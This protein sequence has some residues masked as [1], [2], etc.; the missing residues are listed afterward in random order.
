MAQGL[1]AASSHPAA[2][3]GQS[4][5]LHRLRALKHHS[6]QSEH[7]TAALWQRRRALH[8]SA[9]AAGASGAPA[10]LRERP[11]QAQVQEEQG[12]RQLARQEGR[13]RQ[14]L[15]V[16]APLER[17]HLRQG[18]TLRKTQHGVRRLAAE[19]EAERGERDA[20]PARWPVSG[21]LPKG[22]GEPQQ[23]RPSRRVCCLSHMQGFA[24]VCPLPGP[25]A[26]GSPSR[27]Q[28]R[29]SGK[30]GGRW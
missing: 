9:N 17:E 27:T 8:G 26:R 12:Q 2:A 24:N 20:R 23:A 11:Q 16:H 1:A 22:E 3:S 21:C 18:Q 29:V 28:M 10:A 14:E 19:A 13:L 4:A 25:R 15:P 7:A 5:G 6:A 30:N